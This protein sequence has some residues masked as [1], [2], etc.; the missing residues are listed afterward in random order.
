METYKIIRHYFR[1]DIPNEIITRGLTL[2]QA[3]AHC[4]DPETSS[5]TAK[6]ELAVER[7]KRVGP[8]FDG[9]DRER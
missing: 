3:Q 2:A 4:S 1:D 9:Y 8:W 7:T 6:G 5:E